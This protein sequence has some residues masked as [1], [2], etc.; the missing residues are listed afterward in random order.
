MQYHVMDMSQLSVVSLSIK[1]ASIGSTDVKSAVVGNAG[2][3]K[4]AKGGS[5]AS[6]I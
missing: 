2:V 1:I 5:S 4:P 3:D 6:T